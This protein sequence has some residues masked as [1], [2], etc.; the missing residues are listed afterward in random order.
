MFQFY[1]AVIVI[2]K[3]DLVVSAGAVAGMTHGVSAGR[4]DRLS[5]DKEQWTRNTGVIAA[6]CTADT[7]H[8]QMIT[9]PTTFGRDCRLLVKP[10]K[11][12]LE[13]RTRVF[14]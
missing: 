5:R 10:I 7:T 11:I 14:Q 8:A 4:T 12:M 13:W 6:Q 2:N 9:L 3:Y 1:S